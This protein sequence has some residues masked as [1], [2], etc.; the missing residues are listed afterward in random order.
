NEERA[1]SAGEIHYMFKF[2]PKY[3]LINKYKSALKV[4]NIEWTSI[5]NIE[6]VDGIPERAVRFLEVL[7]KDYVASTTKNRVDINR[8]TLKHI[9]NQISEVVAIINQIESQIKSYR[10]ER[11]ILDIKRE[12][13][14]YYRK[15]ISLEENKQKLRLRLSSVDELNEYILSNKDEAFLP[16][17]FYILKDNEFLQSSINKLYEAQTERYKILEKGTEQALPVSDIDKKIAN[18]KSALISY[19]ENDQKYLENE[20][21]RINEEL[22]EYQ[23][24]LESIPQNQRE[25]LNIERKLSVNENMYSFLLQKRAENIISQ[26]GIVAK[27]EVIEKP[28]SVGIVGPDKQKTVVYFLSAGFLLALFIALVRNTLFNKIESV[29]ELST[30]T[31]MK[32][33]ASIPYSS[34]AASDYVIVDMDTKGHITECFRSLR[35][36][37]NFLTRQKTNNI[38]MNTSI[39]PSEGK[40]FSSLNLATILAKAEK[41]VL[42]F[43]FD[44]HKP[45]VHR[46]LKMEL[47]TGISSFL[48]GQCGIDDMLNHTEIPNLDV[49]LAGPPPPNASE[50]IVSEKIDELLDYYREK[51]DYII[52]DTPPVGVISDGVILMEKVDVCLFVMNVKYASRKGLR[53]LEELSSQTTLENV[54]IV[55]NGV[56]PRRW[57]YYYRGYGYGYGGYGYGYGSYGYG[58]GYTY[59]NDKS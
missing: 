18:M 11:A 59:G 44:L 52:L 41:K 43:D 4:S 2:R 39:Y 50:L 57:R 21:A 5:L 55:L 45:K 14:E 7:T 34:K 58:Y 31:D 25:L 38:I 9:D 28:R 49:I 20:L 23:R 54:A 8:N 40:T 15:Y 17:S 46:G 42:L 56:R 51:Y 26:A 37:L 35:T 27:T 22:L 29:E 47:Q 6:V 19:L 3:E 32:V 53:Y 33:I 13:T 12:E 16:P 24:R 1:R 30:L 10:E 36:N 48:I